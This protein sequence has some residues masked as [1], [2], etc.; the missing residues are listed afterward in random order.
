M[1]TIAEIE[2]EIKRD[3]YN[4]D[5]HADL[6][7]ARTRIFGI[8]TFFEPLNS[9]SSWDQTPYVVKELVVKEIA[10]RLGDEFEFTE[11]KYWSCK[12]TIT[13]EYCGGSGILGDHLGTIACGC[14]GPKINSNY[15]AAFVHKSTGIE[16]NLIPGAENVKPFLIARWPTID[17]NLG[18]K[19]KSKD[20]I[21]HWSLTETWDWLGHHP[22]FV[23]PT[24]DQWRH[25]C[26]G[27]GKD[28]FYFGDTFDESHV[29]YPVNNSY[30]R[31]RYLDAYAAGEYWAEKYHTGPFA[32]PPEW[33][34]KQGKW[35]GYGLVDM[36]GNVWEWLWRD[37]SAEIVIGGS[38]NTYFH[39]S[40]GAMNYHAVGPVLASEVMRNLHDEIG[41]RV[42]TLIPGVDY[43][44][45]GSY[46]A[47]SRS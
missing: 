38:Y 12:Y 33:H 37:D 31:P 17:A 28:L 23:L 25:A 39:H 44:R 21:V 16:L 34:D 10:N 32:H 18:C 43:E 27:G 2:R 45:D 41:F 40:S 46:P 24:Y 14:G 19:R 5:L 8:D 47:S 7:R 20:Y 11:I 6:H 35:N 29:W 42:V 22:E 3:P 1:K 30:S 36:I 9:P 26:L 13:C 15:L 4:W